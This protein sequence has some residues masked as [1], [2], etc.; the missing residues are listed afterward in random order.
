MSDKLH[1]LTNPIVDKARATP[2]SSASKP[3]T[4]NKPTITW[5]NLSANQDITTHVEQVASWEVP[6]FFSRGG[7]AVAKLD[8]HRYLQT[9]MFAYQRLSGFHS[10]DRVKWKKKKSGDMCTTPHPAMHDARH[11]HPGHVLSYSLFSFPFCFAGSPG[12]SGAVT[13]CCIVRGTV[14]RSRW[15]QGKESSPEERIPQSDSSYRTPYLFFFGRLC[16][17]A[18]APIFP[19]FPR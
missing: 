6:T 12:R 17:D 7:D 16:V 18:A 11:H 19:E 8:A 13:Y 14:F 1:Y 10:R 2:A 15:R 9:S 3:P 5:T 4:H